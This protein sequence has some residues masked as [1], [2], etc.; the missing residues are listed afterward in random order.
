MAA[1]PRSFKRLVV[2]LQPRAADRRVRLAVELAELL[3][4]D[5]LGLFLEDTSLRD[6]AAMPFAREFRPLNGGWHAIDLDRLSQDIEYAARDI[7]RMFAAAAKHLAGRYQF[8][9]ARGPLT[10]TLQSVSR[11][12]DIVMVMEPAGA[13]ERAGQQFAWLIEAAFRSSADVMI[14]PPRIARTV[15]PVVAIA[16]RPDDP[17]IDA[18]AAIARSAKEA[19]IVV[20]V[21]QMPIDEGGLRERAAAT[22]RTV[23]LISVGPSA[24]SSPGVL[25]QALQQIEERLIVVTRG[26]LS[27]R[28]VSVLASARHIPVLIVEPAS[29][30]IHPD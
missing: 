3:D 22:G 9:V 13:A 12:G 1:A 17:G 23:R 20:D 6:L 5:L 11:T 21:G 10:T 30:Q 7:E 25:T 8:E 14:V 16:A 15:G 24:R 29:S 28:D 19:L 2:G 26:E 27:E 4:L 18:A